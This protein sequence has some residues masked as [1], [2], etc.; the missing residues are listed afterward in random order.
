MHRY[1]TGTCVVLQRVT[2]ALL[3]VVPGD[4]GERFGA[5]MPRTVEGQAPESDSGRTNASTAS[6]SVCATEHSNRT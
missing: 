6:G 3:G 2:G 4:R 5:V 1:L